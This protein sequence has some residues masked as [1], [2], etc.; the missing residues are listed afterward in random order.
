MGSENSRARLRV[1]SIESDPFG[2]LFMTTIVKGFNNSI[3][4]SIL[5][6]NGGIVGLISKP[7]RI[8]SKTKYLETGLMNETI[9]EYKIHDDN[10]GTINF[11]VDIEI[12]E[13]GVVVKE[14]SICKFKIK[15]KNLR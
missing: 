7:S 4:H 6:A 12:I 2:T 9:T 8:I 13:E 3:S 14:K 15:N 5:N 11:T 1:V 10:I